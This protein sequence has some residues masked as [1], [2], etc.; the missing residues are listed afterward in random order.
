MKIRYF[1]IFFRIFHCLEIL[2]AKKTIFVLM[3]PWNLNNLGDSHRKNS[4]EILIVKHNFWSH[5]NNFGFVKFLYFTVKVEI[6]I[7]FYSEI[8]NKNLKFQYSEILQYH[9]LV[10][11]STLKFQPL[12]FIST[13]NSNT[14]F[15]GNLNLCFTVPWN[16]NLYFSKPRNF[17]GTAICIFQYLVISM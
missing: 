9:E 8:R 17:T 13:R 15:S 2:T 6:F 16:S 10:F 14:Y 1:F 3:L 4:L 12:E 5:R 7:V 11:Y